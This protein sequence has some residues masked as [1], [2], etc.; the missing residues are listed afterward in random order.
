MTESLIASG[1][2]RAVAAITS[3][4]LL[5]VTGYLVLGVLVGLVGTWAYLYPYA[6]YFSSS[7][8]L[9]GPPSEHPIAGNLL[10]VLRRQHPRP[11]YQAWIDKYGP[12]GRIRGLLGV[13]RIYTS[14]PA[15]ISH[16]FQHADM[17]PKSKSTNI[18]L[19]RMLGN[20]LITAESSDHR[21][22]RRVLNPAFSPR[23]VHEMAPIFFEKARAVREKFA[24]L[25]EESATTRDRV[26]LV[27]TDAMQATDNKGGKIDV[28]LLMEQA[29]LDT[30]GAAGFDYDFAT[31]FSRRSEL[32]DAFHSAVKA[33]Q[34]SALISA[35]Q[36]RF[37]LFNAL[38]TPGLKLGR[39]S[40]ATM[41]RVGDRI[42]A[43]KTR[44]ITNMG[45]EKDTDLATAD[46]LSR[47]IRANMAVDLEERARL[48]HAEVQAQ[49]CTFIFAG[50]ETTGVAL[51]WA[52][53]RLA[54]DKAMQDRLRAEL[55]TISENPD[56]DEIHSLPFLEKFT[57][58]ILRMD[59]PVP[60]VGREP[61]AK[62]TLPLSRPVRGRDG[63]MMDSVVVD[64]G[65]EVVILVGN[66]NRDPAIWGPDSNEFNPDRYD[67]PPLA[68]VPGVY[69]NLLTFIGGPRNCIGWRLALAEFKIILFTLLR[70]Y[71]LAEV[72]GTT[73]HS[74]TTLGI[75]RTRSNEEG[76]VVPLLVRPVGE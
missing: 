59:S 75:M 11:V 53:Y 6:A 14:D 66:V 30:I 56:L 33:L 34:A 64:K 46:L 45:I 1:A 76:V 10:Y 23:A 36:N 28:G 38:P 68:S 72:P 7:R 60:A 50:S 74:E 65:T 12:T 19:R 17:W 18:M 49:I 24:Q 2:A 73:L 20:G 58:E 35:L 29:T 61:A 16:I 26:V 15:V 40:R 48:S 22:Q 70:A 44:A 25:L 55:V 8:N 67:R 47:L 62:T 52:L 5:Q 71:E 69:G 32:L 51:T 39:A 63:K 21:R 54:T 42:V 27:D 43:E 37:V 41:N 9:P 3:L 57:R 4:S 13:E 31:L